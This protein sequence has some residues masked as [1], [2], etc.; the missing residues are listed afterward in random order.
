MSS[1]DLSDNRNEKAPTTPVRDSRQS[2]QQGTPKSDFKH[3]AE[4]IGS[5][6]G[7]GLS[8]PHL[9]FTPSALNEN[10]GHGNN[11]PVPT[12]RDWSPF[13]NFAGNTSSSAP[14]FDF[15]SASPSVDKVFGSNRSGRTSEQSP[16]E[17][18]PGSGWVGGLP[19]ELMP[20]EPE[21][22]GLSSPPGMLTFPASVVASFSPRQED[23]GWGKPPSNRRSNDLFSANN[24]SGSGSN[25]NS[26]GSESS[27]EESGKR[28]TRGQRDSIFSS[29]KSSKSSEAPP[30]PGF[31]AIT[32]A[33]RE[34]DGQDP[35]SRKPRRPRALSQ[36]SSNGSA[37]AS[38]TSNSNNGQ[39]GLRGVLGKLSY[40]TNA[41]GEQYPCMSIADPG[42]TRDKDHSRSGQKAL[43]YLPQKVSKKSIKTE[44]QSLMQSGESGARKSSISSGSADKS[45][46]FGS[47]EMM[48]SNPSLK[49][50]PDISPATKN[51]NI[52]C[53][54]KK[55]KCLKLYCDCF[56]VQQYC[57]GCHCN[58]CSNLPQCEA[59]RK[60]AVAAITERNPDAFKPRIAHVEAYVSTRGGTK[61][62]KVGQH[63]QGCH[64][65]K[66]A[67][68]KK[69]CECFQAH[70]ACHDRCRCLDCKNTPADREARAK[71]APG[72]D[73]AKTAGFP[74]PSLTP[75]ST[76]L[77]QPS[78]LSSG[79]T[80]S[81]HV[82]LKESLLSPPSSGAEEDSRPIY[83]RAQAERAALEIVSAFLR[84]ELAA[85]GLEYLGGAA[86]HSS[87]KSRASAA[88]SSASLMQKINDL[89]AGK[90]DSAT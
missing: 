69:Y 68:L 8:S 51:T 83:S 52:S 82:E 28:K 59:E 2:Q 54:C 84:G 32:A 81:S 22:N 13:C 55:S 63:L 1:E 41:E 6:L 4:Q 46:K 53:N 14:S 48:S 23:S 39:A 7:I 88:K 73:K 47:P 3:F 10:A 16:H 27:A 75:Q 79:L 58:N 56:R 24:A 65:K 90:K 78:T 61:E 11:V 70:V 20:S 29:R 72:R 9:P 50:C 26:S 86:D 80:S 37:S 43:P 67:C 71:A 57:S 30:S 49:N 12:S 34:L 85:P 64:C 77:S 44:I 25:N 18:F 21:Q 33:A 35:P 45:D 19:Q 74:S 38:A 40:Q 66:S 15:D 17:C 87:E 60:L 31:D 89:E 76:P 36:D 42:K 62:T 5:P